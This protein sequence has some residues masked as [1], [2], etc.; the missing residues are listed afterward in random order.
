MNKLVNK[1]SIITYSFSDTE[2]LKMSY[3]IYDCI[4]RKFVIKESFDGFCNQ[5]VSDF[6]AIVHAIIYCKENNLNFPIYTNS[7]CALS[8]IKSKKTN[9]NY[10]K[11][12]QNSKI[13][14]LFKR[15]DKKN[16]E[17][18]YE[19]QILLWKTKEFGKIANYCY[20]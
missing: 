19:N 12:S 14:R 9:S 17:I 11:T 7:T 15:A 18:D 10:F 5:N 16:K 8:W 20:Q 4:N 6:I 1:N 13:Y 2:N 3:K